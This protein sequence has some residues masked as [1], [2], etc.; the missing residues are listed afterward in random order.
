MCP[1]GIWALVPSVTT[2]LRDIMQNIGNGTYWAVHRDQPGYAAEEV[3]CSASDIQAHINSAVASTTY[4]ENHAAQQI[5]EAIGNIARSFTQNVPPREGD[6]NKHL[7]GGWLN[8]PPPSPRGPLINVHSGKG[9]CRL[10]KVGLPGCSVTEE[11]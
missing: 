10:V 8:H 3:R 7:P 9:E 4:S 5:V 11:G 2:M 1:V 6:D